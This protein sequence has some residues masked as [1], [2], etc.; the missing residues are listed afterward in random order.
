MIFLMEFLTCQVILV[1]MRQLHDSSGSN[2]AENYQE[3]QG[4]IVIKFQSK[5]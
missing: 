2:K 1:S 5:N 4:T 3:V